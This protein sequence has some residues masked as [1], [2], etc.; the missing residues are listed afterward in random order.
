MNFNRTQPLEQPPAGSQIGRLF[1]LIDMGSQPHVNKISGEKWMQREVRLVFELPL[2]LMEGKY[3][4]EV[5]GKPFACGRTFKQSLHPSAALRKML[6][7]WAGKKMTDEFISNFKPKDLLG[8]T[9]RINL[10]ENG[11]FVDMESLAK[12]GPG[13]ACPPAVNPV[14]Y[15][16][17]DEGEFDPKVLEGLGNKMKETIKKSPEYAALVGDGPQSSPG[18]GGP[19]D[20]DQDPF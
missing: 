3:K 14:V 18:D 9:A 2:S 12:L 13:D 20:E 7:G 6:E 1:M 10:V 16:S 4:P 17:L 5:K 11:S 19:A 8:K 15:F